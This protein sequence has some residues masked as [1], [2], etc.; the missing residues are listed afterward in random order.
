MVTSISNQLPIDPKAV[1]KTSLAQEPKGNKN[2]S[3]QQKSAMDTVTLQQ[4]QETHET[5]SSTLTPGQVADKSYEMLRKLVTS[6]LEEQ[7]IDFKVATGTSSIDIS[8]ISQEEAQE[9]VADDG[10]FG[11]EQTSDRIVDLAI[12]IAGGD[13]SRLDAVKEGVEAGFNEA[14]EA[15]GGTLPDISYDTYDAVL[16]KLDAWAAEANKE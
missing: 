1:S 2:D 11:I 8:T 6:M 12:A 10:Y 13:V 7:G 4:N 5:Y 15:F 3:G 16:E 9:L 14:L